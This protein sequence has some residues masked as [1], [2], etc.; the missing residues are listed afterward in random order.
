M[1]E[2]WYLSDY[3]IVDHIIFDLIWWVWSYDKYD[4]ISICGYNMIW[5]DMIWYDMMLTKLLQWLLLLSYDDVNDEYY[6][7]MKSVHEYLDFTWFYFIWFG[8][9]WL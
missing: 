4:D 3:T 9:T 8:F 1:F 2:W 6:Y 5:Y 7:S